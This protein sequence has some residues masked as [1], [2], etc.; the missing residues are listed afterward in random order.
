MFF[1]YKKKNCVSVFALFM[2]FAGCASIHKQPRA[3]AQTPPPPSNYPKSFDNVMIGEGKKGEIYG[4]CEP[5]ISVSF[6]DPKKIAAGAILDRYYWSED[7]GRK[8]N[9][10]QLKSSYGVFGDPVLVS[11]WQGNFYYAHLSNPDGRGWASPKILDRIVVQKSTDGGKT[12]NDGGYCG[13][14]HPKDQD[15]QWLVADPVSNA[16]YCSW[17]E[18]DRYDSR[19]T[20]KDRSRILFSRSADGGATWTDPLMLSQFSGDCMD[21]DNTTEGAVPAVGP[22]GEVY[23]AW[24][25]NQKIWFDRSTDGGKTWLLEDI[26]AAEQP[27]GWVIDIPGINRCNGM[28]VL[29]CDL[30]DG[31]NRGTLY[32]NWADQ[33]NG[34]NDVDIWVAK[35]VDQGKTWS[36][37]VRVNDDKPGRHQFLPWMTI[38]QTTGH[39][40]TVFYDRR[41]YDDFRTDVYVAVSRDGGQTFD[42]L[43]VSQEPFAPNSLV[44]F[45]DYNHISAHAGVVRPIWTRYDKEV[46]SIWTAIMDFG[47]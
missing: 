28:P 36:K 22:K 26:V 1:S 47:K 16:L 13:M 27:G 7:G 11:D 5:S 29:A 6:K 45:G 19:D 24:A 10:G 8:W 9:A 32:V 14:R 33:K 40:Y 12:Y 21:D 35:S 44:F 41:A 25:W 2:L 43:K 4:P 34:A 46:L 39:L 23:V 15:K 18:F 3:A 31:P 38:D 37:P 20:I 30:S 17:T 42:N